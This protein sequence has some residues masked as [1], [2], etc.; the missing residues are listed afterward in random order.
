V[1]SQD[2]KNP[3]NHG[4]CKGYVFGVPPEYVRAVA[5]RKAA[6]DFLTSLLNHLSADPLCARQCGSPAVWL[7]GVH[8]LSQRMFAALYVA[9]NCG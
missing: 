3:R 7:T 5:Y 2:P 6:P 1:V 9:A 4:E 8:E